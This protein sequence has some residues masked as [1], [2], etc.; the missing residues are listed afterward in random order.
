MHFKTCNF[1]EKNKPICCL[2]VGILYITAIAPVCKCQYSLFISGIVLPSV[3]D[4]HRFDT[5]PYPDPT[6][7][8]DA[9]AYPGPGPDPNPS[10][11]MLENPNFFK[12]FFSAV[13]VYIFK[14]L[15]CVIGVLIFNI[16]ASTVY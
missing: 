5:D 1:L 11:Y 15:F 16:L 12:L 14:N 13:P 7:H 9:I 10:F 6:F 2:D 4:R 3:A 8:L